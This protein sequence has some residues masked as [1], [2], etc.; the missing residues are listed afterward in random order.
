MILNGKYQFRNLTACLYVSPFVIVPGKPA[1]AE[2]LIT[3]V[4]INDALPA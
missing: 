1:V 4:P 2:S 3:G